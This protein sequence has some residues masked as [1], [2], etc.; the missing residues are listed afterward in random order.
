MRFATRQ[1]ASPTP[2]AAALLRAPAPLRELDLDGTDPELLRRAATAGT[3]PVLVRD[4]PGP[5]ALSPAYRATVLARSGVPVVAE[6]SCRHRNRVALEGEVAALAD[7][8]AAGV[9]VDGSEDAADTPAT[10]V[11]DLDRAGLIDLVARAGLAVLVTDADP[12]PAAPPLPDRPSGRCPKHMTYGP[13]GGVDPD[14]SCEIDDAPCAF[15]GRTLPVRWREATGD[16]AASDA[17]AAKEVRDIMARRPVVLSGLPVR[18]RVAAD[19]AAAA[20]IL[21][22]SVDAVL[23]GDAGWSRTQFPPAYRAH[24]IAAAG[25]RV[26]MG[27][28][29]RDRNRAAIDTELASLAAQGVAGVHLVTGDHTRTGDRPD[30]RPVFDLESTTMLPRARR[31]GL[32]TSFAES[33][34]APPQHHRGA[35]V[36]QKQLA[37]GEM[38]M[39]QYC[40]DAAD[41]ADFIGSCRDA[42]ADVPVLP[43]VPLVID[44]HGAEQLA[45]FHAARLPTGYVETLLAADDVTATGIGL[46]IAY[47]RSLLAVAGVAGVVVAGGARPGRELDQAHA[48]AAVCAALGGGS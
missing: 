21:R 31:Q 41:V 40:G 35:R 25:L 18:E 19:V 1:P 38:C 9:L 17:P 46:A 3:G 48:L 28:N 5:R 13:C 20:D 37:G 7:A 12:A 10:P 4:R 16:A 27:V 22:G 33:P 2:A 42:G 39:L 15:L 8:G 36:R 43:G 44:R 47:G 6:L 14:G 29:A 30:A 11:H 23:S 32:F 45:G 34:A 26:W 24:L